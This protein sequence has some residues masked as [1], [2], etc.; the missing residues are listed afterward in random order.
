[1]KRS[2]MLDK[3]NCIIQNCR[4]TEKSDVIAETILKTM[5]DEGMSPSGYEE[6]NSHCSSCSTWIEDWE[7]E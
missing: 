3:I 2:E 7:Q 6:P 1:M 5:E 4:F